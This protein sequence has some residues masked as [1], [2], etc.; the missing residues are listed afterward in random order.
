MAL[1]ACITTGS[2]QKQA[3]NMYRRSHQNSIFKVAL[4]LSH[5]KSDYS[6][7]VMIGVLHLKLCLQ[8]HS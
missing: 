4:K 1:L 2:I 7:L 5:L 8:S 3:K 6:K